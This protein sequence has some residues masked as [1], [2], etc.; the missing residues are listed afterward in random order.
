M[1]TKNMHYLQ[2]AQN[3]SNDPTATYRI[4]QGY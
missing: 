2:K 4:K 1:Q 3:A